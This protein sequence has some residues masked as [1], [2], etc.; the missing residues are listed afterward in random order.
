MP[1]RWASRQRW[2]M[3]SMLCCGKRYE[4]DVCSDLILEVLMWFLGVTRGLLWW[5]RWPV[6]SP[7]LLASKGLF[8][9]NFLGP[10]GS[11]SMSQGGPCLGSP[12]AMSLRTGGVPSCVANMP[13]RG[14]LH[15]A[16]YGPYLP[17]AGLSH[18]GWPC[19]RMP[20]LGAS[21]GSNPG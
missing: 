13:T 15:S 17:S 6:A 9:A 20:T 14:V 3:A 2:Q 21:H 4:S 1:S 18:G 16:L 11:P 7:L 19:L 12:G 10:P 5:P 8:K